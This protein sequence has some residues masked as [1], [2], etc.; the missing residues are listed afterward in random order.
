MSVYSQPQGRCVSYGTRHGVCCMAR[1]TAPAALRSL[2]VIV[3]EREVFVLRLLEVR[4]EPSR[5]LH[6][7]HGRAG[8]LRAYQSKP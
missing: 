3:Y 2:V 7:T 8:W 5:A 1:C 4:N 6:Q